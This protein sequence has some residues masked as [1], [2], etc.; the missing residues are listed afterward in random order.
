MDLT[1]FVILIWLL[2][3]LVIGYVSPLIKDLRKAR[4]SAWMIA[5]G[6]AVFSSLISSHQ[7]PLIRMVIIVVLQLVSM[8]ILVAIESYSGEQRLTP[9]QWASF[10]LGWFGM[11]P[12]PFE[13]LRSS[14]L[15]SA[16]ILWKG[17]LRGVIGVFLLYLSLLLQNHSQVHKIFLSQLLLLAG[18]SLILHF[19]ILN[20]CTAFWRSQGANVSELFQA[21]Y[22]SK[23]LKEFWGKRWNIAFSEMTALIAYRPLKSKAGIEKALVISF[24]LSGL[25]HEVAISLPV[26]TGF[27]LPMTYFVIQVFAMHLEAHSAFLQKLLQRKWLAHA[28][29]MALLIVPMPLL[30]HREFIE[31]VLIPLR[32]VVLQILMMV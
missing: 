10:T 13:K 2:S 1:W 4:L 21:P 20:L 6:T 8:K 5:I 12:A 15:P 19:G 17:I 3:L 31:Q 14:S 30:F 32:T 23:S 26:R 25:L 18:L 22:K 7:P 27:G 9:M 11:R 16:R 24:L 28:W 29:V